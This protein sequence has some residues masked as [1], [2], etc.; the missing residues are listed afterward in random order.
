[1]ILELGASVA[2]LS[3][4]GIASPNLYR[5]KLWTVGAD[6]GLNSSPTQIL[7]AY[8][9]YQPI[10]TTPFVWSQKI[11]DFNEAIAILCAFLLLVKCTLFMLHLWFP[12]F[13]TLVNTIITILWIVSAYGQ[14]GPDHSDP[15]HPSSIAWYITHSCD[16]AKTEQHNWSGYCQ[17]AKA[18]FGVTIFM[19]II[20][21]LNVILGVLSL[22]PTAAMRAAAVTDID[23]LAMVSDDKEPPV[24]SDDSRCSD[25][26]W[27][28]SRLA[29]FRPPQSA[30]MPY[31]PRTLAFNTLDRR[32]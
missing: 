27:E 6:N 26:Q 18:S 9:N 22:I 20:F 24:L 29:P 31:T 12:L 2:A 14:A 32:A 3:L 16:I 17:Q 19:I 11:T 21:A 4:M 28:M 23:D 5:T 25:K 15:A 8:A 13:G 30:A 1:M 7:Y 10:P